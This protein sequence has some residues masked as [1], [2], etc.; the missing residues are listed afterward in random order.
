MVKHSFAR[1]QV[2]LLLI[3]RLWAPK[4]GP[5]AVPQSPETPGYCRGTAGGSR[6]AF[7]FI[8]ISLGPLLFFEAFDACVLS[9][10]LMSLCA[11]GDLTAGCS[12][13]PVAAI[14]PSHPAVATTIHSQL[15][16]FFL[17]S[18]F[19][20]LPPSRVSRAWPDLPRAT[21]AVAT[22]EHARMA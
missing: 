8:V 13:S 5:G 16:F 18:F 7:G 11:F 22:F 2:F 3:F 15:F 6:G 21:P 17:F 10:N 20:L 19:F 4:T 1:I 9:V 14:D 12:Q